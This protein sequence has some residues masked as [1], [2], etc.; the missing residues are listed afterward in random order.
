MVPDFVARSSR[1]STEV[2]IEIIGFWRRDYLEKKIEKIHLLGN[3][4]LVLLVNSNLSVSWEELV[5]TN[6][7]AVRVLFYSN[8]EELKEAAKSLAE[9][10]ES[11]A[12]N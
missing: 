11:S 3:R 10:L 7:D 2:L 6:A 8:R 12:P 1:S 9:D 4:R 5:A